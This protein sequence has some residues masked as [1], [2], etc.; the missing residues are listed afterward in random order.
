VAVETLARLA[1]SRMS[2]PETLEK[3]NV[4]RIFYPKVFSPS[5]SICVVTGTKQ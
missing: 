4:F 1:I 3:V 5:P 2:I